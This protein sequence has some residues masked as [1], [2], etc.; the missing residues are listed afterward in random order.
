MNTETKPATRKKNSTVPE[1]TPELRARFDLYIEM[2]KNGAKH[3]DCMV[4]TNLS[5]GEVQKEKSSNPTYAAE[6]NAAVAVRDERMKAERYE[7][8]HHRATIGVKKS[9][10]TPMGIVGYDYVPSDRLLEVLLKRDA[11]EEYMERQSTKLD[12]AT[13]FGNVLAEIEREKIGAPAQ[14][15]LEEH[16]DE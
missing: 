2:L 11:P 5:W 7:A 6:F 4:A 10:T 9:V 12:I 14:P 16:K 8:A 13:T 1:P 15:L 3:A